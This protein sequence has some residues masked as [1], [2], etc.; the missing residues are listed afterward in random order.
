MGEVG[1]RSFLP[2]TKGKIKLCFESENLTPYAGALLVREFLRQIRLSRILKKSLEVQKRDRYYNTC[3]MIMS[4]LYAVLFGF[5]RMPHTNVLGIDRAFLGIVGLE[6]YPDPSSLWRFLMRFDERSSDK[7]LRINQAYLRKMLKLEGPR[8]ITVDMDST[9]LTVYGEQ[10][11]SAVGYNPAKPGRSSYH[12]IGAFVGDFK[13]YVAGELRSGDTHTGK[14]AVAF[15]GGVLDALGTERCNLRA[16]SGFYNHELVEFCEDKTVTFTIVAKQTQPI[17]RIIYG[18]KYHKFDVDFEEAEFEY[19]PMRW[20]KARR[21]IVVRQRV[22]EKPSEQMSF[23][24]EERWRYQVIVTNLGTRPRAVWRF[25]NGRA[26]VENVIK[27]LKLS[28]NLEKIPTGSFTANRAHFQLVMLAYNLLNWMRR[29]CFPDNCRT[30]TAKTVRQCLFWV[31]GKYT[32]HGRS[33]VLTIPDSYLYR[34]QFL[35]VLKGI[36]KLKISVS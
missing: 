29:L 8:R 10:E 19:A 20:S 9:V 33:P 36:H 32:V 3:E 17:K 5:E 11:G 6:R 28:L 23:L 24:P 30:W 4:I 15:F 26:N 1:G 12:P 31:P 18:L 22:Q 16:D 34:K 13:D 2:R 14:D 7:L 21:F 35:D 25:Y 27:E